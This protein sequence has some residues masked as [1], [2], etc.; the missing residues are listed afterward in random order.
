MTYTRRERV[1]L[2]LG[3]PFGA[4]VGYGLYDLG[5]A[6]FYPWA[7]AVIAVPNALC[8]LGARSLRVT[9]PVSLAM[10]LTISILSFSFNLKSGYYAAYGYRRYAVIHATTIAV[11]LLIAGSITI[12]WRRFR[13]FSASNSGG[14]R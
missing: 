5:F 10:A 14:R 2:A 13:G 12:V 3:L 1:L 6:G 4:G 11:T 9:I 7:F 8:A